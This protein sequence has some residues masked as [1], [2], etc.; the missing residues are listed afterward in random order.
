MKKKK[1][2]DQLRKLTTEKRN[3]NTM[4][5]DE[6]GTMEILQTINREDQKVPIAVRKELPHIEKAVNLVVHSLL[7]GGRLIYVGAGTSG[8]LGILDAAECPPTFGN[9]PN[10]IQGIIAGGKPAVFRS[11]EGAEDNEADAR[12]NIRKLK[13]GDKDT[14]CG[15]AASLRTPFVQAA[16]REAKIRGAS[17]ILITTNPRAVLNRGEFSRIR[18][19]CDVTICPSVGPEVIMGSTR[20]KSG[21]AQKMILNMITTTSMIKIGKVYQNLMVDLRMN[22]KKLEERAKRVLMTVTGLDYE[23]ATKTIREAG[24]HVK[25]AIVMVKSR[26]SRY[27]AKHRLKKADGFVKKAI[28]EVRK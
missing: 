21:S 18:K 15:I 8:R 16:L 23:S 2:F 10:L 4:S 20:M 6:M 17:T 25:T 9:S 19:Y 26:L 5:I 12:R 7:S 28:G 1:L 14:V 13:V 27:E 22:S 3:K 11:Q 24:G